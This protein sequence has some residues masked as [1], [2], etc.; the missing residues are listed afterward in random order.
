MIQ[1]HI[2]G[3][4]NVLADSLSR[5]DQIL[6][7]EWSLNQTVVNR[8]FRFWGRLNVDLFAVR[9]NTKLITF[10]SPNAAKK[11]QKLSNTVFIE[12]VRLRIPPTSMIRHY[13]SKIVTDKAD[14]LLVAPLWPNQEWFTNII[15]LA[16]DFPI[17]LLPV[18]RLLKQTFSRLFLPNPQIPNL[19]VWKFSQDSTLREG[20]LK[21]CPSVPQRQSS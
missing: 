19:L 13:L 16:I 8:L 6:K 5:E 14:V 18:R 9:Q 2:P 15:I 7:S 10:M 1:R 4:M 3:H 12:P 11:T 21:K 17:K 20:F